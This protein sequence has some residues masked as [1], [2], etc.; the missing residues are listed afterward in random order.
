MVAN[1]RRDGVVR[2]D[3]AQLVGVVRRALLAGQVQVCCGCGLPGAMTLR[4]L[5]VMSS[6]CCSTAYMAALIMSGVMA[7][8]TLDCGQV[9]G[10]VCCELWC[11]SGWCWQWLIGGSTC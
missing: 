6:T 9:E 4:R 1:S 2:A 3:G 8:A 10:V 11:G 7:A 5:P